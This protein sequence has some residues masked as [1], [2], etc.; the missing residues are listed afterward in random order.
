MAAGIATIAVRG[1]N[2]AELVLRLVELRTQKLQPG[3]VYYGTWRLP[4]PADVPEQAGGIEQV[5]VCQTD[6]LQ[7]EVHCHGGTAICQAILDVLAKAG[8]T[9]VD[10]HAWPSERNCPIA[11]AAET[12]L[13]TTTTDK[14]AGILLDQMNGALAAAIRILLDDLTR[15]NLVSAESRMDQLQRWLPLGARLIV[16]WQVVFAGPPNVGK[17]S[18][19]NCV[20]GRN[21]SIVHVQAGTTRDWVDSRTA[22]GGWPV[23][24]ADTAGI[25]KGGDAIESEGIRRAQELIQTTDLIVLVIDATMG[26]QT[27]HEQVV[28]ESRAPVLLAWNKSD[29]PSAA[30]LPTESELA[31]KTRGIFATSALQRTG[32]ERLI[33]AMGQQLVPTEPPPGE[34]VPF[35]PEHRAAIQDAAQRLKLGDIAGSHAQLAKLLVEHR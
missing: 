2:A 8:A 30:S 10:S 14:S 4:G 26:I 35:R 1:R 32:I 27:L 34:A 5:V 33:S 17:S 13:L 28:R 15:Q 18:L 7:V 29:L 11:A 12:D 22:I 9:V 21:D 20:T 24:I 6:A 16:P 23:S 3:L 19:M 31:Q 25:R